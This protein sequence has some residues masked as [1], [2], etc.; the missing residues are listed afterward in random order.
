MPRHL[1]SDDLA[2]QDD[3]VATADEP[4]WRFEGAGVSAVDDP[5]NNQTLVTVAGD[6]GGSLE[7]YRQQRFINFSFS[8]PDGPGALQVV[9]FGSGTEYGAPFLDP[10]T[11]DASI[12][13]FVFAEGGL[14]QFMVSLF[15]QDGADDFDSVAKRVSLD[16]RISGDPGRPSLVRYSPITPQYGNSVGTVSWRCSA[17]FVDVVVA[18]EILNP[19]VYT[20]Y[21]Y[22]TSN[23]EAYIQIV[24]LV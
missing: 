15:Q 2:V 8:P 24:K 19:T 11:T 10:D 5:G 12:G 21:D 18:G 6:A 13:E 4:V 9:D 23:F 22:L 14:Y 1:T 3:G 7:D 17:N 16:T 20:G